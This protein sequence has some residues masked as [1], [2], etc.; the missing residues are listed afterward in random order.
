MR[1]QVFQFV[2]RGII[3]GQHNIHLLFLPLGALNPTRWLEVSRPEG[4]LHLSVHEETIS[5]PATV[6]V[7]EVSL[8]SEPLDSYSVLMDGR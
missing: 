1:S 6:K 2:G 7:G 5:S 3:H 8:V 4:L